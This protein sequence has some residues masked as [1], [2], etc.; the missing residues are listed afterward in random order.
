MGQRNNVLGLPWRFILGWVS[1]GIKKKNICSHFD[2]GKEEI[3]NLHN[4]VSLQLFESN[5]T[6]TGG[7]GPVVWVTS[8]RA[9]LPLKCGT[10]KDIQKQICP[11]GWRLRATLDSGPRSRV[12]WNRTIITAESQKLDAWPLDEGPRPK[13]D[14]LRLILHS[15]ILE[16]KSTGLNQKEK[17][18]KESSWFGEPRCKLG[19]DSRVQFVSNESKLVPR[20]LNPGLLGLESAALAFKLYS[21]IMGQI[22]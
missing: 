6:Q 3:F 20:N 19:S 10:A 9:I 8:A 21:A 15:T 7:T 4:L 14:K 12:Q 17:S 18:S 5:I 16:G 22:C 2:E 13:S 11:P 1:W